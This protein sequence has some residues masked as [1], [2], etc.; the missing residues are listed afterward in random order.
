MKDKIYIP[1]DWDKLRE[2]FFEECTIKEYG[3]SPSKG[4]AKHDLTPYNTFEWFKSRL[5][6][7]QQSMEE[8]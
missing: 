2:E 3:P 8:R 4:L 5:T 6:V 1:V 7:Q